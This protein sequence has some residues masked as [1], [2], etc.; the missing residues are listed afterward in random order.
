MGW[1]AES[2]E[3]LGEVGDEVDACRHTEF[4]TTAAAHQYPQSFHSPIL[5][6]S[7]KGNEHSSLALVT[8]CL[9]F[10]SSVIDVKP[11]IVL[12]P[13]KALSDACN[14]INITG[15]Y[16][17]REALSEHFVCLFQKYFS[18]GK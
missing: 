17:L 14:G 2:A 15:P 6:S 11:N 9:N 5:S 13:G 8:V 18:L 4:H 7:G 12:L 10:T 3:V 16:L 1:G